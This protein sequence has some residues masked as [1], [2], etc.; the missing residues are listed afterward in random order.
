M[1]AVRPATTKRKALISATL[2]GLIATQ[3]VTRVESNRIVPTAKAYRLL[4]GHRRKPPLTSSAARF[5]E[6]REDW[7]EGPLEGKILT[8]STGR[9]FRPKPVKNGVVSIEPLKTARRIYFEAD[10]VESP[11]LNELL[12]K[13]RTRSSEFR[14]EE[15]QVLIDMHHAQLLHAWLGRALS[16]KFVTARQKR[17][18]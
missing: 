9:V 13:L 5:T 12:V 6:E 8:H 17:R 1:R 18:A 15:K 14:R 11:R 7:L 16:S 4:T 3:A 2:T 10:L